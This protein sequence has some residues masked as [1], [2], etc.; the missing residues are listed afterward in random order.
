MSE[1]IE[2]QMLVASRDEMR[3]MVDRGV[4]LDAAMREAAELSV[5]AQTALAESVAAARPRELSSVVIARYERRWRSRL[6]LWGVFVPLGLITFALL[7][8]AVVTVFTAFVWRP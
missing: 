2:Q 1:T 4:E 6:L 3:A 5:A 7:A 8:T